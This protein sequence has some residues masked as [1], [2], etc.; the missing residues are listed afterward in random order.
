MIKSFFLALMLAVGSSVTG[1]AA[2]G[3]VAGRSA[4][5]A[6]APLLEKRAAVKADGIE[7]VDAAGLPIEGRAFCCSNRP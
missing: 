1:A 5:S 3:S 7:W 2:D 6:M 4:D